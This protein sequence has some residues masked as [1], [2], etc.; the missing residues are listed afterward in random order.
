VLD[1]DVNILMLLLTPLLRRRLRAFSALTRCKSVPRQF[2]TFHDASAPDAR[3][4]MA[5][6]HDD[7]PLA[8]ET[9]R[10]STLQ[11][12]MPDAHLPV[13]GVAIA[14]EARAARDA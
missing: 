8:A 12:R 1:I 3:I 2:H 7:A 9:P 14:D 5:S 11:C 13:R 10:L 6:R 4:S